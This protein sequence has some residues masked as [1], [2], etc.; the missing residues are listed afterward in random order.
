MTT[1][2]DR[3]Y[4][5]EKTINVTQILYEYL[6]MKIHNRRHP[7]SQYHLKWSLSNKDPDYL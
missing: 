4:T 6:K 1:E 3:E 5:Y 2:I 7:D